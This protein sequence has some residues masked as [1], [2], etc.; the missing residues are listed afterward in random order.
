MERAIT[1]YHQDDVGDWVAELA[2]GHNQ[3]VRHDPP[4][5]LRAWVLDPDGRLGRLGTPLNCP[6]C[7]RCEL[8]EGLHRVRTSTVWDERTMPAGLRRA[9]RVAAGTWGRIVVHDGQLRFAAETTPEI[10]LELDPGSAQGIPPDVLHE[11]EPLGAVRFSVEFFAIDHTGCA[12]AVGRDEAMPEGD[13]ACW[14]GSLCPEC[15]AV[16][17]GGYHRPGCSLT[18]QAV[19]G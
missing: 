7:D 15:G 1:G 4:F 6:L 14:A 3:H 11:V 8:P 18:G 5:R 2:C 13:P 17:E 9:H 19:T 16:S 10:D 12:D